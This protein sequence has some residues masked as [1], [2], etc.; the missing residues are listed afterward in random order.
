[1]LGEYM[2]NA[3]ILDD[4]V[5]AI[6]RME[7]LLGKDGRVKVVGRFQDALEALDYC[8]RSDVDIVFADIEMPRLNG[9]TFGK[10]LQE[11][12]QNSLLVYITAYSEYTLEAFENNAV[13]YLLK[14]IIPEKLTRLL[15]ILLSIKSAFHNKSD[16]LIIKTLGNS[17]FKRGE[18][19][20]TFRTKKAEELFCYLL[21]K[22]GKWTTVD[23]IIEALWPEKNLKLT[24]KQLHT[25]VYY[26]RKALQSV[27]ME[28][29]IEYQ[30]GKYRLNM[31]EIEWDYHLLYSK[32]NEYLNRPI[33][34][35]EYLE[36]VELNKG[37]YFGGYA[38]QWAFDVQY[39]LDA[40]LQRFYE[41]QRNNHNIPQWLQNI[42]NI[43]NVNAL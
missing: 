34:K 3:I 41:L 43:D 9:I 10:M 8:M 17:S 18:R 42:S 37:Y 22:Q 13:G 6:E 19:I 23:S 30:L 4:E 20:L 5:L 27:G 15:N 35:E 14:P 31:E 12:S 7:R 24:K 28:N 2:K 25:T 32:I 33:S 38:Y 11:N 29:L 16:M 39:Q 36:V 40:M 21:H 26:C 1:M